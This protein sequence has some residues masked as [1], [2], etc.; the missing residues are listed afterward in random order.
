MA[1]ANNQTTP[2]RVPTF[3][4]MIKFSCLAPEAYFQLSAEQQAEYVR[5]YQAQQANSAGK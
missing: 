4:E 2:Q 5:A 1:N 3:H